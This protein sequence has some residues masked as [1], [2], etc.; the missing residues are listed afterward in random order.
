MIF[1]RDGSL[2]YN[3]F[4]SYFLFFSLF[5][6]IF[7][8]LLFLSPWSKLR[9]EIGYNFWYSD[10]IRPLFLFFSILSLLIAIEIY[11]D[12]IYAFALFG[13]KSIVFFFSFSFIEVTFVRVILG[14]T[15]LVYFIFHFKSI[16]K[17]YRRKSTK[18]S[19][20]LSQHIF[21]SVT[22]IS[23]LFLFLVSSIY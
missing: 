10:E 5:S 23:F 13:V 12:K 7:L 22:L 1:E 6:T 15:L 20:S 11:R 8:S 16:K 21:I 9:E 18:N 17:P 14:L 4:K 2:T 19:L 3:I